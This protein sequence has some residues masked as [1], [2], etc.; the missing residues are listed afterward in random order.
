MQSFFPMVQT[1]RQIKERRVFI[2]QMLK[3]SIAAGCMLSAG[4]TGA[5]GLFNTRQSY[6]VG[7][8]MD[9]VIKDIPGAPFAQTVDTLKSGNRQM[10]VTG[11]VTTMFATVDIIQQAIKAR[12]NFIIAHE[13]TFY[14][15]T[16]DLNWVLPNHI[17]RQKKDLLEKNGMAVWR[18]HDYLH[19]FVPD[20]VHYGVAKKVGWAAYYQPGK[21]V[22]TV[23]AVSL[24]NLAAQLKKQLGIAHL[25]V[26]G[27]LSQ[28]C[29]T[30]ALLPGASGGQSHISIVEKEKP[31]VLVVGEVHEWETAEYIRDMQLLGGKTA[32]IVLGHSV[33]EEPGLQWLQEWLQP[34]LGGLTV[35]HIASGNPFTWL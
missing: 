27:N 5:A 14:N 30:V 19:A 20:S 2:A 33:S 3:A 9:L 16:D 22:I 34:K 1:H 6:T 31:D 23:P 10:V 13:P 15:H 35:T 32:L 21:A 7:D 17:V 29:S 8:I 24:G 4:N 12:A 18:L 11:I 25:R 26:I 28:L